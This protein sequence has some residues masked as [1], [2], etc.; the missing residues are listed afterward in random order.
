MYYF[1]LGYIV[2]DQ[3]FVSCGGYQYR[4]GGGGGGVGVG[5]GGH[6][7]VH[8]EYS[9]FVGCLVEIFGLCAFPFVECFHGCIY[10]LQLFWNG[11][12]FCLM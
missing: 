9:R 3:L 10:F 4:I 1:L 6:G 2:E 12:I 8:T 5:D 11:S 7:T